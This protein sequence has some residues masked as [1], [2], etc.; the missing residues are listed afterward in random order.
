M[1]PWNLTPNLMWAP[2]SGSCF[3]GIIRW[4]DLP[5]ES[6]L[7][8]RLRDSS[9]RWSFTIAT[10]CSLCATLLLGFEVL[11]Y[12]RPLN[13]QACPASDSRVQLPPSHDYSLQTAP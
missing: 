7:S 5:V 6:P 4:S 3:P 13:A 2:C 1:R 9:L 11:P 10:N 8:R 12:G